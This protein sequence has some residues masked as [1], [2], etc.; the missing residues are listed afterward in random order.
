MMQLTMTVLRCP[1]TVAPE[2]RS[3]SGGEYSV[4]RGPGV[5]WVLPDPERLLSKRHF[6]V[7]FRSGS[8][9]LAD[10]STNG[11]F[12]NREADPIGIGDIRDLRDGDRLRLGAYEIEIRLALEAAVRPSAGGASPFADPFAVDPFAAIPPPRNPFD[13]PDHPS[14]RLRPNSAQ[15]PPDFDPLASDPGETPFR[16]PTQADNSPA[17][18]DAWR[19]PS[20]IGQMPLHEGGAIPGDGLLPDD[21]DEDLLE[22]PRE[23]P[24]EGAAF[25]A[26][27]T[28]PRAP[29]A[30]ERATPAPAPPAPPPEPVQRAVR[31]PEPATV[32]EPSSAERALLAAFLQ[33]AGLPDLEPRD[34]AA[35]LLA[36]GKAFRNLVAGLRAVLIARAAI[37]S[38]FR[39]G[40]TLIQARGNNPLK[41]SA[42]DDDA[43]GALLGAGRHSDMTPDEAVA[44]ALRDIRLHELAS[45]AAMQTAVR[46]LLQG[47]DPAKLRAQAEHGGV[48]LLPVQKKAR[49][50]D[51]YEALYA[52][53]VQALADDF[54]SVFGKAFARAYER[55]LDEAAARE[56]SRERPEARR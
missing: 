11:T 5:D 25:P 22:G 44:D 45:I 24:R 39:I 21:W 19:P 6:A 2:T 37:K 36:L 40:Q 54:D 7:A 53:T 41:F 46:A 1:Q 13:E 55:A 23:S 48:T 51:A 26:T 16:G 38:E 29:A 12:L 4:G 52:K 15:L 56:R 28:S 47:L 20:H 9:Q 8:W 30:A 42:D 43:L 10:T 50:W 49:A 32:S 34:P 17:L 18:Q 14:L 31:S 3:V 33:G 27:P 35:T